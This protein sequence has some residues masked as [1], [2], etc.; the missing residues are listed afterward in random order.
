MTTQVTVTTAAH[1]AQAWAMPLSNGA[2]VKD[3]QWMPLGTVP[4]HSTATFCCHQDQEISVRELPHF[5]GSPL[6]PPAA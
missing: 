2:C 3:A 6:P 5:T 1:P 4:P